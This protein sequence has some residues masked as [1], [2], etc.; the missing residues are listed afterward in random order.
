MCIV[1]SKSEVK[2]EAAF[3]AF[4]GYGWFGYGVLFPL[5]VCD[6]NVVNTTGRTRA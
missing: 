5:G 2:D 3:E 1:I 6:C 4:V